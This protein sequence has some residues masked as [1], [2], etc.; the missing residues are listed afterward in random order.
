MFDARVV[1]PFMVYNYESESYEYR[2]NSSMKFN[3]FE[4]KHYKMLDE[5]G[6]YRS[7][8]D[9]ISQYFL[10]FDQ[11][12]RQFTLTVIERDVW[13][14]AMYYDF[15][16]YAAQELRSLYRKGKSIIEGII[17]IKEVINECSRKFIHSQEELAI[18]MCAIVNESYPEPKCIKDGKSDYQAQKT[19]I[20]TSQ[21]G[22]IEDTKDK[23]VDKME[24]NE[25][26]LNHPFLRRGCHAT[27]GLV[28][29]KKRMMN[30]TPRPPLGLKMIL[31]GIPGDENNT[32]G[33]DSN[34]P[35]FNTTT[36]STM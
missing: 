3:P 9:N 14:F 31:E 11:M 26:H 30:R 4:N 22:N 24:S 2:K 20:W 7:T 19:V 13:I 15:M 5:T 10:A 28:S 33:S 29:N 18:S 8:I 12:I 27:Q 17:I 25:L 36:P 21:M 1:Y 23:L 6:F 16:S 34:S 35:A 32:E